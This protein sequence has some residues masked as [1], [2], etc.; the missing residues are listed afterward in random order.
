MSNKKK[1]R[2]KIIGPSDYMVAQMFR[3]HSSAFLE[4]VVM[5]DDIYSKPDLVCFTGGPDVNP[6]LYKENKI[7]ET[8]FSEFRDREDISFYERYKD[9]PKVGICR[10]GQLLNVLSGGAMWQHVN[11]HGSYHEIINLL[12]IPARWAQGDILKVSSTHHQMMI[13]GTDGEVLA[14]AMNKEQNSGI[15]TTYLS[16]TARDRPIFDTEVVWY[17]KTKSLCYQPHPEYS[18]QKDN[19][20]YFFD[21]IEYFFFR[22]KD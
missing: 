11:N 12:P 2:V 6:S 1:I 22:Q 13:A 5:K 7:N 15:A 14:I 4:F 18:N 19:E 20:K 16:G 17:E 3:K 10:G 9:T 8:Q 21:L